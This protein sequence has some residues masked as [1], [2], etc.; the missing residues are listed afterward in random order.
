MDFKALKGNSGRTQRCS[1]A[2]W[3]PYDASISPVENLFDN[4]DNLDPQPEFPL[5]S[6]LVFYQQVILESPNQ[7]D[8]PTLGE[9]QPGSSSINRTHASQSSLPSL[10]LLFILWILGLIA[11]CTFCMAPSSTKSRPKKKRSSDLSDS[12]KD[13]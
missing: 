6:D 11:W 1:G 2:S 4:P 9:I 13:V 3:V 12:Y 7:V 5:R 8:T 10:P